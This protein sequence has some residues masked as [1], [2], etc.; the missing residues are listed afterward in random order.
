M[1]KN[2]SLIARLTLVQIAILTVLWLLVIG[3]S[4]LSIYR[5]GKSEVDVD[6]QTIASVIAQLTTDST[7]DVEA[8]KVAAMIVRIAMEHSDPAMRTD[9]LAYQL[10][11]RDGRLLARTVDQPL[12]PALP[13]SVFPL[14]ADTASKDWHI[15]D[16]WNDS[17]GIHVIVAARSSYYHR[18][19]WYAASQLAWLWLLLAVASAIAFWLSF[20]IIIRPVR[21]LA[22]DLS[23]RSADDLSPVDDAGA[24]VEVQPLLNALNQKLARIRAMLESERQFFAD[25]AHE[26]RTPLSVIGAQAHVLAHEPELSQRVAAL[27]QIEGGIERGARVISRLLL[28]GK[29]EGSA[30]QITRACH[31]VTTIAATVVDALQ[32]RAITQDQTLRLMTDTTVECH[33]DAEAIAVV[34]ENLIDNALRYSPAG[35]IVEVSVTK[36]EDTT[37]FRV[38]DNGPGIAPADRERVFARFERL[39][40]S[41]QTGSGL[42]LSIVQRIAELHGGNARVIDSKTGRGTILEVRI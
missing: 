8:Q 36:Q 3:F 20:R 40:A 26:L 13:P 41:D 17:H 42:G 11:T 7:S 33:C 14:H 34:L 4:V 15:Q 37:L 29:L 19:A 5:Q 12:L 38:S 25:A 35:A 28:L 39:G 9:E 30:T 32:V 31:D 27:R 18:A 6:V 10:W 2:R 1:K 23:S 21:V 16:A 22:N 24:F